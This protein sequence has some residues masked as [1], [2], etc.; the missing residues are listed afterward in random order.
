MF[1]DI[2]NG[3]ESLE[4]ISKMRTCNFFLQLQLVVLILQK[5]SA[6]I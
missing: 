1:K 2:L 4:E 5:S 6:L 3:G